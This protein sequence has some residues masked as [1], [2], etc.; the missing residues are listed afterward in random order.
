VRAEQDCG[1]ALC[2]EFVRQQFGMKVKLQAKLLFGS[3]ASKQTRFL[4]LL[5]EAA[6]AADVDSIL[7]TLHRRGWKRSSSPLRNAEHASVQ[8]KCCV[9][10][11]ARSKKEFA[12]RQW[13]RSAPTCKLCTAASQRALQQKKVMRK[14]SVAAAFQPPLPRLSKRLREPAACHSTQFSGFEEG[15]SCL[16]VRVGSFINSVADA[17][18]QRELTA[19]LSSPDGCALV[20]AMQSPAA[21][22]S[23]ASATAVQAIDGSADQLIM[24]LL[25]EIAELLEEKT[26]YQ[27]RSQH[28]QKQVLLHSPCPAKKTEKKKGG[29]KGKQR[30]QHT[31]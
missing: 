18:V 19:P 12:H 2:L 9:C 4:F 14:A 11:S 23:T 3:A 5:R 27:N 1:S 26:Y 31:D 24:E 10:G 7:E 20:P 25:A 28:W 30:F 17:S 13:A 16:P 15:S 21:V 29:Q 8:K 6:S 22:L